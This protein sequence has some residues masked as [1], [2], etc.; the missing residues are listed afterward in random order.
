MLNRMTVQ[1][2]KEIHQQFKLL[3]AMRDET[4]QDLIELA[5]LEFVADQAENLAPRIK[6]SESAPIKK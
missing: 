1:I 3:S 5:L 4:I 2:P 6:P